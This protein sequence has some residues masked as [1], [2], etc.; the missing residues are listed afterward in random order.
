M[1]ATLE[2]LRQRREERGDEGGFTLI[3]LL[4]VLV[5]LGILAGIVVFA[6]QNLSGESAQAACQTDFKTVESAAEFYKAQEG[7]YP[8]NV[9]AL[10]VPAADGLGPWLKDLP[11]NGNHYSIQVSSTGVVQVYN[12]AGTATIPAAGTGKAA[13]CLSVN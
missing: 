11:V 1:Q 8:A 13:D 7:V 3:E 4:I 9:A 2:R 10:T 12:S 5:I 6:V